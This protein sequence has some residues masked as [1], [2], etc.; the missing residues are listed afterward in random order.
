MKTVVYI[1]LLVCCLVISNALP[2]PE[3]EETQPQT[4]EESKTL[5]ADDLLEPQ[6]SRWGWGGY[7]WGG[8]GGGYGWG[9]PRYGWGYPGWGRPSYGWG[10]GWG[11]GIGFIGGYG[12]GGGWAG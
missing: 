8:R 10:R 12:F 6:E 4:I 1:G 3:N 11:G 2:T 9:R 5:A 7:G